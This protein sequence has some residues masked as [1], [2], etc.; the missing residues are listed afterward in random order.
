MRELLEIPFVGRR[1]S[2]AFCLIMVFV[3]AGC[4]T[5]ATPVW[6]APTATET[7]AVGQ[8]QAA[9]TVEATSPPTDTPIPPTATFTP[10]P[11]ATSTPEPTL[12]PE[13]TATEVMSPLDRM[14]SMRDPQKGA[15]LFETFQ[16]RAGT[17]YSCANCHSPTSEEK[18][19]GPGLLDIKSRALN[20]VE[21]QS[22]AEY[23][24]NS[25]VNPKEIVVEDYDPE[26]M[27]DNWSEIYTNL[28]IFDIV[29]YLLTLEGD[30][31]ENG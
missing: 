6:Q 24:Y 9:P 11:T 16:E 31:A 1:Y 13:P 22:A 5:V 17:G 8:D 4:G 3:I 20:R 12:T 14:V 29:A 15:I 18:L 27:P 26:L 25:I 7:R 21:G 10:Q 2:R 19:V 28:E 23:I 30:G